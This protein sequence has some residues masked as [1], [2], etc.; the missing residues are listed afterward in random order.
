MYG[1]A[2]P[3]IF[4][5]DEH[6]M[7]QNIGTQAHVYGGTKQRVRAAG[8]EASVTEDEVVAADSMAN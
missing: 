4:Q 5:Q 6:V 8:L 2:V 1:Q 7:R 3:Q